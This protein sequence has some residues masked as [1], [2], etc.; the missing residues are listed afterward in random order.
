[1]PMH[2]L[3]MKPLLAQ[4]ALYHFRVDPFWLQT[5]AVQMYKNKARITRKMVGKSNGKYPTGKCTPFVALH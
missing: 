4:V 3:K 1:M 2:A 5:C